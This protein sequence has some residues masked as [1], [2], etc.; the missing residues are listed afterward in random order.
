MNGPCLE[1]FVGPN[2]R[3]LLLASMNHA[4]A[5]LPQIDNLK[6]ES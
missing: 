5:K 1:N 4:P 6:S 2:L 3:E